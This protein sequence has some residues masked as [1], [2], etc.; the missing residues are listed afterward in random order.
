MLR[1]FLF[2]L[3]VLLLGFGFAWFAERPGDV[4]LQ[5]QGTEYQTTLMVVLIAVVAL[6]AAIMIIWWLVRAILDSP[7]LVRRFWRERKR[8]RGYHALSRGLI[9]ANSGDAASARR[10]TKESV[11]LLGREPLVD[12]LDAQAA[13]LEGKRDHARERFEEMLGDDETRLVGLRGLYIEA[14]RQGERE[15]ARHYAEKAYGEAKALPW[16]ANAMLRYHCLAGEWAHAL[17]TLEASRAAG[18]IDKDKAKRQ[19]AVL[20]TALAMAEEPAEPA[21]AAKHA[22]EAHKLE[23]DFVPAAII[24][25]KA[26]A[27]NSDIGRAAGMLEKVWK[28]NPHP[29]VAAAYVHLRVG[30]SAKDRLK[31]A[32]KLA[33][34]RANHVEGNIAIAEAAIEAQE[35]QAAREALKPALTGRPSERVCLIMAD[36]EEGEHGDKGRMRDWLSRA[37]NAPKDAAWTADGYVAEQWLPV[38]PVSGQL[39]A[40]EWKVPVEQLGAAKA[41]RLDA[42]GLEDLIREPETAPV[43]EPVTKP[44]P[45]IAR[46]DSARKIEATPKIAAAQK[47]E[48][49]AAQKPAEKPEEPGKH[50]KAGASDEAIAGARATAP[51]AGATRPVHS[52][53]KSGETLASPA[54]ANLNVN[55]AAPAA[56]PTVATAAASDGI[57][58]KLAAEAR[59]PSGPVSAT[60]EAEGSAKVISPP[61]KAGAEAREKRSPESDPAESG[62]KPDSPATPLAPPQKA[63]EPGSPTDARQAADKAAKDKSAGETIFP[64][65]RPPDDPGVEDEEV[66]SEKKRRFGLF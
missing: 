20:L 66:G 3:L 13:L 55:G 61:A 18:L 26:L 2:L 59:K 60:I 9:A 33:A 46:D 34:M 10:H 16:A 65:E 31:R 42:E 43:A 28:K 12:L 45:G 36:I 56:P 35:W 21:S 24:G 53:E 6:V 52:G 25:A 64:L 49:P 32:R 40:F 44:A 14:E 63:G 58:E 37:V 51:A 5:W 39:D 62:E 1:V 50:G 7:R 41:A 47:P 27:R 57:E 17:E 22:R 54:P 4:V 8:D 23:P 30:D 48:E 38:S 29:E 11:R 15:A 19:R